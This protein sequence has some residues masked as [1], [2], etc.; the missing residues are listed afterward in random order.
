[1]ESTGAL[2]S[3]SGSL[4][5]LIVPLA[6]GPFNAFATGNQDG[7]VPYEGNTGYKLLGLPIS[8]D[9]NIPTPG[10][11]ADQAIVGNLD[12]VWAFEG[13][14]V[15]R[16]VPQTLAPNLAVLLQLYSYGTAIVRYPLAVQA[17]SGIGMATI[18]F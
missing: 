7:F 17:I 12:E 5:P 2:E 1:M 3:A 9:L 18:A 4:H 11:G 16:V 15:P 6:N 14:L 10:A 13:P 8:K